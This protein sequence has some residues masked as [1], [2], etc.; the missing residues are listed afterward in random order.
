MLPRRKPDSAETLL[1]KT[2]DAECGGSAILKPPAA[3]ASF[4]LAQR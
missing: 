4:N 3:E 2:P 1:H